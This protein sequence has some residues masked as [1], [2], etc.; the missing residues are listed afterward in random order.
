MRRDTAG[1]DSAAGT[2]QLTDDG[3]AS[4]VRW[5]VFTPTKN[6]L[7]YIVYRFREAGVSGE[8]SYVGIIFLAG[9]HRK[10]FE[11]R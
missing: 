1:P 5:L 10:F 7:K 4:N 11:E 3:A 6:A 8:N 9:K 2:E